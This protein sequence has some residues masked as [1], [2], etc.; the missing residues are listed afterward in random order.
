MSVFQ[1]FEHEDTI[2]MFPKMGA[3]VFFTLVLMLEAIKSSCLLVKKLTL[4]V[5]QGAQIAISN[6][7]Q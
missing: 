1:A 2:E 7:C 3:N 5:N 4:L 6:F